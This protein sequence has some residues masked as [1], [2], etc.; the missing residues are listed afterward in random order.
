MRRLQTL[1]AVLVPVA[2]VGGAF[3]VGGYL[4]VPGAFASFTT[5]SERLQ[6]HKDA[7]EALTV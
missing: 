5:R 2:L 4:R 3:W 7:V 1:V 6:V